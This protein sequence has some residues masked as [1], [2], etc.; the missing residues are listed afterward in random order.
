MA[1]AG[2][3]LPRLV[4]HFDVNETVMVG[5]PAGG[6]TFEESLNK[7]V[8]KSA[9]VRRVPEAEQGDGR[10]REW[11]WHD[12]TPLDPAER[13]AQ[14]LSR[15]PP[16]LEDFEFSEAGAE[17]E[18]WSPTKSVAGPGC[19]PPG[20]CVSFYKAEELK[21][22]YAKRFTEPDS[23]GVIYREVWSLFRVFASSVRACRACVRAC[24]RACV[25]ACMLDSGGD[26]CPV[27]RG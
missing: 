7:I 18:K 17:L 10:W 13:A 27:H 6:D 20:G 2:A 5:D 4:L 1:A 22:P 8:A 12:G 23:P 19:V 11:S 24:M 14:G 16:L 21:R 3:G 25:H 9:V 26:V 15:P